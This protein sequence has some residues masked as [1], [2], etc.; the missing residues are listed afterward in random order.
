MVETLLQELERGTTEAWAYLIL[1]AVIIYFLFQI[2]ESEPDIWVI[3]PTI[4]NKK[5]VEYCTDWILSQYK[6]TGSYR[7]P[8]ILISYKRKNL[9]NVMGTFNPITR[10]V[11]LYWRHPNH[12]NNLKELLNTLIHEIRHSLDLR[13]RQSNKLYTTQ[14]EQK[15]YYN[16][17]YEVVAR[18]DADALQD[19]LF[20]WAVSKK[21]ICKK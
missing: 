11:I 15:G 12:E 7:R 10:T 18:K 4:S 19:K 20:D 8:C 16:N 21:L 5:F 13:N 3:N 1:V 2:F 9:G 14:T 6:I 17:D